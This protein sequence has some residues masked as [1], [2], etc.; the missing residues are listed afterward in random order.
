[1]AKTDIVG[2][3][4]SLAFESE[5]HLVESEGE[6]LDD[7][8]ERFYFITNARRLH[9]VTPRQRWLVQ[10]GPKPATIETKPTIVDD[11]LQMTCNLYDLADF[12]DDFPS[13][14]IG[15]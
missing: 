13:G 9:I 5:G 2:W 14:L 12:L 1:M 10:V 15:R 3:F 6:E 8:D 11:R 4:L 7:G